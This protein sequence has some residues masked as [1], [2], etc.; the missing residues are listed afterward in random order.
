MTL[1]KA[2]DLTIG[3]SCWGSVGVLYLVIPKVSLDKC[4]VDE[5]LLGQAP[6]ERRETVVIIQ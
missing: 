3:A 1:Q 4:V 6:V 5:D 2:Q